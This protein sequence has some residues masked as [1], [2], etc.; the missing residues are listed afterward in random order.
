M[1]DWLT[2]NGPTPVKPGDR[3]E[4]LDHDENWVEVKVDEIFASQFKVV[5]GK[6]I[7]FRFYSDKGD[8]WRHIK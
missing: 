4:I 8:T 5:F 3:V 1:N 6:L 7:T 2:Y